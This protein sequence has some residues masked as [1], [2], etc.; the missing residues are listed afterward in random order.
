MH[1]IANAFSILY[2]ISV[3]YAL[4]K[5]IAIK[6]AQSNHDPFTDGELIHAKAQLWFPTF[7][8]ATKHVI[9]L[10]LALLPLTMCRYSITRL[11][12]TFLRRYIPFDDM[13]KCHI[14]LGYVLVGLVALAFTL[15]MIYYTL[16]CTSGDQEFC[17]RFSSEIMITGYVVFALFMTVGVSSYYRNYNYQRFYRIHQ[18]V[19]VAFFV[20]IMHTIDKIHRTQGS[21]SQA[22]KWFTMSLMIYIADRLTVSSKNGKHVT[23]VIGYQA[24]N[25]ITASSSR[26]GNDNGIIVLKL[27]K[28]EIFISSLVI[29]SK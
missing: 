2:Y 23:T 9:H 24:L 16:L 28:P 6:E 3:H 29:M 20:S 11:S 15:F 13:M 19:F 26:Q 12:S 8:F 1:I 25:K 18:I 10:H 7:V 5:H 21:R 17:N 4:T 14:F 27:V 22:Y